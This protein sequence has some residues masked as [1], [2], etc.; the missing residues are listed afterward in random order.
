MQAMMLPQIKSQQ[1]TIFPIL[2]EIVDGHLQNK[3]LIRQI[4]RGMQNSRS[5]YHKFVFM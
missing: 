1:L 3:R 2:I 4:S 5:N